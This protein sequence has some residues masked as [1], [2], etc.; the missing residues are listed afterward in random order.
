M[1]CGCAALELRLTQAVGR[2]LRARGAAKSETALTT[3]RRTVMN[4]FQGPLDSLPL[5][6]LFAATVTLIFAAVEA[7]YRLGR[8]RRVH[9]PEKEAP[10]GAMAAAMLGLLAF[11]L[12]FT[13]GLAATRFDERRH[14]ILNESNAI[15]TTYL[16]AEMLPSP[17]RAQV[18]ELLRAYVD[19]RV[20]GVAT[21]QL[22]EAIARSQ[23]LQRELW[24]EA[25]AVAEADPH[26]IVNGLFI[27]SLNE[28]I[29]LHSTRV[30]VGLRSRIPAVIWGALY[31]V[32]TL[33]MTTMGY[34]EGLTG[35]RR[36]L[37]SFALVVAFSS[38]LFMTVDLDRPQ[39]GLLR[40]SQQS[41]LDLQQFMHAAEE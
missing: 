10:V 21:G 28:M 27:Q 13:F 1:S 7:G 29:D 30:M 3:R 40:I 22:N 39:E 16:R 9:L 2:S 38:I 34:H 18:R 25:T 15:G 33:T 5:W 24:A 26:S 6:L 23:E 35:A 17:N 12:A 4:A 8:Y 19:A 20:E 41:V 36:S 37:A 31:F 11:M 32:A 14:A